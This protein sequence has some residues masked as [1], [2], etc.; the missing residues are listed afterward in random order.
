MAMRLS[1][2][3]SQSQEI[4]VERTI[5]CL[6]EVHRKLGPGH[7]EGIY[8]DAAIIELGH[9][10]LAFERQREVIVHYRERPCVLSAS[11]SWSKSRLLSRSRPSSS[12]TRS[13]RRS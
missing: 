3:L 5:G 6:I 7:I 10:G 13:T 2:P 11:I 1:S 12:C 9:Q 8:E 4:V